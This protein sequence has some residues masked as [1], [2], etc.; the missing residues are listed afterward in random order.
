ML[1]THEKFKFSEFSSDERTPNVKQFF[2][3]SF[4]IAVIKIKLFF[5]SKELSLKPILDE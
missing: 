1:Y 5:L 3:K 2:S 4:F